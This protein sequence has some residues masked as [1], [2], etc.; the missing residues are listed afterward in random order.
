MNAEER[1][2]LRSLLRERRVLTL[3]VVVGA[4][5]VLGLLPFAATADGSAVLVH[6][7]A[8]ARHT[9]G[10]VPGS[11]AAVLI[12]APDAPGAAP[13]QVPRLT[14]DVE[15]QPLSRGTPAFDEGRA[16]Y[17]TRFPE[18]EVTF[19]LGDFQLFALRVRSGRLVAGFG[20][21]HDV[22]VADLG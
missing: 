16:V 6:A 13:L 10:L 17:L 11:S 4:A 1:Q 14:L 9:R 7:S 12:H 3:G 18:A 15:V 19:G 21:A 20:R 2:L 22:S 5:P 8:L